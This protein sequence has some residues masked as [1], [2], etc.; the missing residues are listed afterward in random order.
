M[1]E[2]VKTLLE[3]YD[4]DRQRLILK[5]NRERRETDV[6]SAEA[7]IAAAQEAAEAAR[8]EADEYTALIAQKTAAIEEADTT[9]EQLRKDQSSAKTN[10]EY[11]AIINGIEESK[12]AQIMAKEKL[13]EVTAAIDEIKAKADALLA[14]AEATKASAEAK[15]AEL[16]ANVD[17]E[18]SEAELDRLYEEQITK[19]DSKFLEVYERLTKSNHPMPLMAIDP[20]TRATVYGNLISQNQMEQIR[21]GVLCI[22]QTN[23]AILYIKD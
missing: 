15:I 22:D 23:N 19:V 14:E 7:E 11:M 4:I 13:A 5:K 2:S 3:L 20:N 10:K 6:A 16:N 12:A 9:I 21:N 17:A 1:H 8:Q 18:G